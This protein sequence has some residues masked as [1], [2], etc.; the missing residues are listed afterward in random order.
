MVSTLNRNWKH[1]NDN[2]P[3]VHT[4]IASDDYTSC[5]VRNMIDCTPLNLLASIHTDYCD[6]HRMV[7]AAKKI[8]ERRKEKN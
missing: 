6:A 4:T 1:K 8:G 5:F 3:I 7:T 2:L